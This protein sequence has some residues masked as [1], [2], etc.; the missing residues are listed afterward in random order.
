MDII[1]SVPVFL[2]QEDLGN[3]GPGG[4]GAFTKT[5]RDME[6]GKAGNN[7]SN[8]INGRERL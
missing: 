8:F 7:M 6:E 2:L 3:L 1:S 5:E 4:G